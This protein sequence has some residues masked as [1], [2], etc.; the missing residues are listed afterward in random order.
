MTNNANHGVRR[1][2][3]CNGALGLFLLP[4]FNA[5]EAKPMITLDVVLFSYLDRPI[6]D[7]LVGNRNIG[8]AGPFPHSGRG[9][10]S[11]MQFTLGSQK[12]TWTLDGPE[13]M[14]RNGEVVTAKN[15]PELKNIPPGAR[16]LAVHIYPDDTVEFLF[17]EHFPGLSQQG[18]KSIAD[19]KQRNGK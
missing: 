19:R 2:A 6:F 3:F 4:A 13:G 8:V 9:T 7:V 16:Y 1:R 12:V 5:C 18:E 17:S 14:A 11:G 10:M 15:Q